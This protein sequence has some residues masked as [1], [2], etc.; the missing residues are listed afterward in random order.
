MKKLVYICSAY[1]GD[2]EKNIRRA[3]KYC[4]FAV[5]QGT[6]PIAPHLLFPQFM[7]E[8]SER[9]LALQLALGLMGRCDE[10]WVFRMEDELSAGMRLELGMAEEMGTTIRFFDLKEEG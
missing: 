5:E 9:E 4:R 2:V 3:R 1:S 7:K 8:A 10:L 6:V